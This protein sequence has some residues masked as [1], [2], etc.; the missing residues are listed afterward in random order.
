MIGIWHQGTQTI[1]LLYEETFD[2]EYII[3]EKEKEMK[4]DH[5]VQ[6]KG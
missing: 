1:C 2:S 6:H 3:Y 4:D 5:N